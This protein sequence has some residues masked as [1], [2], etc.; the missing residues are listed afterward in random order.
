MEDS[1]T[2][3]KVGANSQENN[4]GLVCQGIFNVF[5]TCYVSVTLQCIL[6]METN[7]NL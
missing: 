7:V 2:Q 3:T 6:A 5:G 1:D 4:Y